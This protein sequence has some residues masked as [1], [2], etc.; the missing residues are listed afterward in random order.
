MEKSLL[1][2]LK[3]GGFI[4]YAR[5]GEAKV[6]TDQPYF[7]FQNCNTQRNLSELGRSEAIYY[8]Q[9]LR[10][11]Q[12]PISSPIVASPF[13]RTIETAQLA[14]P[15]INVQIDAFWYNI[16]KLGGNISNAEQHKILTDLRAVLA[17]KPPQGTN[18]VIIAHSFPAG[19]GLGKIS[20]LGTVIVKPQGQGHGY[21]IV[22][23]LALADLAQLASSE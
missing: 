3:E 20:N 4:L 7:N 6:G 18:K 17:L 11:L 21:E 22:Q 1:A 5:H 2:L 9:M 13:C 8:G 12:I 10:Y 19:I 16:F 14:F 23:Q 15:N